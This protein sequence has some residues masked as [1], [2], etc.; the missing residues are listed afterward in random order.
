MSSEHTHD[1]KNFVHLHLHTEYSLL[2]GFARIDRAVKYA[3][4]LGMPALAISDHGTMFGVIDFY[5]ACKNA[6]IKP[7]IGVE[8]YLARRT[9]FDRDSQKDTRP[10]HML[11]LAQNRT[12]YKN[13]LKL[14]S[15][16][17]L[18][19]YYYR[20]RIDRDLMAAHAE[21]VIATSGCLAAEIPRMVTEGRE[22]EARR[23]LGWYQD[24]Y[25]KDKFFL[26]LQAHDIPE[27][28]TVNRWLYD[29]ADYANVPLVATNDVH[30]V[31]E[32][33]Y[34]PHDLLLCIQTGAVMSDQ[35]RMRMS[36]GN[37]YFLRSQKEMW[38]IFGDVPN[39]LNNTLLI[40]EMCEDLHLD[41]KNYHLPIF[42]VPDRYES[43]AD[44]LFYLC[45]KGTEW[46]YRDRAHDSDVQERL[47]FELSVISRM[48]FDTYFLIVWDLCEFAR[49][50]DIWWN[51]RGSGAGSM[52]A[53]VLGI[54]AL[55]P[56][57]VGLLFERFLNPGRISM[58]DLDIDYPED[59][60]S[61]MVEYCTRKYGSDKVAAIITFGTLGA[62]AAI[63]DVGRALD[64]PLSEVDKIARLVPAI[65]KPPKINQLLGQD[66]NKPDLASNE[67]IQLYEEDPRAREIIDAAK[68][69]EGVPRHASTHA[70]GIIISDLPLVEYIPLHRPT[71]GGDSDEHPVKMVTQFP[72]ETAESIGLLK[73]DFLGLSTLTIM[74]KAASLIEQ[75]HG[76][77]Y[78]MAN[79]PYRP[80]PDDSELNTKIQKM[81]EMLGRG[82]SIG[83]FQL[84]SS[85][86][87]QMLKGMRPKNFA[88]IMA[89]VA[90]YRPGPMQFI[91]QYNRRL[92]GEE[93]VEYLHPNL[94]PIIGDTYGIIIYQEQIMK[95]AAQL[96][97]YD[98]GEAD[99][100]RKA[101]S[102]K[103]E[104]DLKKHRD[105]F[106]ERGPEHGVDGKT[107]E[108]IFDQIE[109]FANYGF[110]ASHAADYAVISCQTAFLKCHYPHE[111]MT[112]L[113]SVYYD[114]SSKVG[115]FAA[116][117]ARMGI[118]LLRPSINHSYH[119][120]TIENSPDGSRHIRY[121][122]G[123]VK[124]V[125]S[126]SLAHIIEKRD[127]GGMFK[128]LDD[129]LARCDMRVVGKRAL[130]SLIRVG[131]L[132][133]LGERP[134]LL[135]NLERLMSHSVERHKAADIGQ[136]TMFDLFASQNASE[137]SIGS[138]MSRLESPTKLADKRE[139]LRWE[140]EL[141]GFYVSDHPLS[142]LTGLLQ[143]AVS[144]TSVDLTEE[145]VGKN[146]R[147]AGLVTEVRHITT[148]NGDAMAIV[149]LED[150]QGLIGCVFFP[151][152]W[153]SYR[154]LV[155]ED[156]VIVIRGKADSRND[157]MQV[158]VEEVS[159]DITVA[160][161]ADF[162]SLPS[163]P[164]TLYESSPM[165]FAD[166]EDDEEDNNDTQNQPVSPKAFEKAPVEVDEAYLSPLDEEPPY[167][168]D[169]MP[170]VGWYEAPPRQNG[171]KMPEPEVV[172]THEV[173]PV[174]KASNG[175]EQR[176]N[177]GAGSNGKAKEA[178]TD[179]MPLVATAETA[180]SDQRRRLIVHLQ[181][182]DD[183]EVDFRRLQ[184]IHMIAKVYKG[185]DELAVYVKMPDGRGVHVDFP[186]LGIEICD[187]LKDDLQRSKFYDTEVVAIEDL[188][189]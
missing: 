177:G 183:W 102:K 44:Y 55:D 121:G 61:E 133:Q 90:L 127:D 103:R 6:D 155:V 45:Q 34:N 92:H 9:R 125:G 8:A 136:M 178:N 79:I 54:T 138:V 69:I 104:K 111:Y 2:D 81:F 72:M 154:H 56:L 123:A 179:R 76:I 189:D 39:A 30:Y 43:P 162:P 4:E 93:D 74:R 182:G 119:D 41:D 120:F 100:I 89:A 78:T 80:K 146:V 185:Q 124:N 22:D 66:P 87:R 49:S 63:R 108:L 57:E 65:A 134:A 32:E 60:R 28:Q 51:V 164:T 180:P 19:G 140:K 1:D 23:L 42:P 86:M 105:T 159:K 62:K 142:D 160:Q 141:I 15:A 173:K 144:H 115:L 168:D 156:T 148:K 117:C 96:F 139:Q 52:V 73:V 3:A 85:G 58:P 131:A 25:G 17:Q 113:M 12:G 31:R 188:Q 53:Y 5:R 151:R 11:L 50:K 112:A 98:L 135:H 75:H 18:E 95:I 59:R 106:I 169:G 13:L 166:D 16:A 130:E 167:L 158:I 186:E 122:L 64:I 48:G 157:E 33:D 14:T 71:K 116:D 7:I 176:Q 126:A 153:A 101:V 67:F 175:H 47:R 20:P 10:F 77:K 163:I 150:M 70:A 84:E 27:L 118:N 99:Q 36:G 94:E 165:G 109:F 29:N 149:Q 174:V 129:F 21:G 143:E 40:A 187:N 132:D 38:D 152:T 145:A 170:D 161:S 91:P 24:V 147:M 88:N 137:V 181:R 128:D 68:A 107:A 110:N 97:G 37:S 83:V 171:R 114:D 184:R 82:E 46:R 35:N 26:E 172:Q